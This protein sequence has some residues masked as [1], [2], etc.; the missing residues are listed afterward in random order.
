MK[1]FLRL[2]SLLLLAA[3]G[4]ARAQSAVPTEAQLRELLGSHVVAVTPGLTRYDIQFLPLV[5]A[6]LAPCARSQAF[7]PSGLRPW[8]RLSVGVRCVDG[9]AWTVMVPAQVRVWGTALVAQVPL[10]AG[11]VP[12]AADVAEQEVELSREMGGL[13]RD[14]AQLGGRALVRPL[15]AGQVL[16]ADQLRSPTVVQAG[17][18]VRLRIVGDGFAITS[19]GQALAAASEGQPVRVRTEFGRILTGVAREGRS[20]DIEP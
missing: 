11:V 17:E 18:A 4:L 19:T 8:G 20:V 1:P 13:L 15:A 10:A 3:A 9:A 16:R 5:R 2:V 7:L 14:L 6:E 12:G